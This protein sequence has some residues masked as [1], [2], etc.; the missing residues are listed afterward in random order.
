MH[1]GQWDEQD[2]KWNV[3][4]EA[5]ESKTSRKSKQWIKNNAEK[6]SAAVEK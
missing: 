5:E 1:P 4:D 6:E 3:E 2:K